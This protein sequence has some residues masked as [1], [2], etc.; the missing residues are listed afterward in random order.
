M[1]RR[2]LAR[3][4]RH[5]PEVHSVGFGALQQR[6]VVKR[7]RRLERLEEILQHREVGTHLVRIAPAGDE[8]GLFI[9]R[10]VD[11]VRHVLHRAENFCA[12]RPVEQVHAYHAR[13][14]QPGRRAAGNAERLPS[15]Q[16]HEMAQRVRADQAGRA[17]DQDFFQLSFPPSS[18]ARARLPL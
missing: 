12:A 15:R 14:F 9:E 17:G 3:R 13:R 6:H 16:L 1:A 4:H 18:I 7:A 5:R 11:E 2:A 10:R 8:A